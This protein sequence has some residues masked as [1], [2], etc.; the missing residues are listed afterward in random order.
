MSAARSRRP[1][2]APGGERAPRLARC[3][4]RAILAGL[5]LGATAAHAQARVETPSIFR[6]ASTPAFAIR[7]LSWLVLGIAGAIF[8]LVAGVLVVS[9]VRFRDRGGGGAEPAQVYGSPRIEL[10]WTLVPFLIVV[11][12]FLTTARYIFALESARPGAAALRVRVIGHQWWWEIDYPDLG[13]V[14]ANELH[15]PVSDPPGSVPTF[16][17]LESA[18]V[19]HSF[20]VPQLAGKLDLIPNARNQLWIDPQRP[21]TYVGQCAEFC[22]VQHAGML[23]RVIAHPKAEFAA[24]VDAQRAPA[25]AEPAVAAGR[26]AFESAACVSC[27]T[28]RGTAANGIFG[29]DLTHLMSRSTLAAGVAPNERDRLRRWVEDP[30]AIKPGALMPA[31]RLSPEDLDRVVAYLAT[32]R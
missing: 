1:P 21:G 7:E 24:W 9:L 15:V 19:I 4:A 26:R 18:D 27:H 32:L 8:V 11:V 31:M 14:T 12:L 30:D 10:A 2:R 13:V 20:W 17:T 28:V 25:V 29:P 3:A 6:P 23:L 22:G 16:L 5:W